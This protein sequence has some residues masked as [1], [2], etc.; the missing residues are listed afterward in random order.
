MGKLKIQ[1]YLA[2]ML[3]VCLWAMSYIWADRLLDLGIPVE[4]FVPVRTFLAGMVGIYLTQKE[5]V[6][7]GL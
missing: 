4:F 2:A 3:T 7:K 6:K 5:P 1:A